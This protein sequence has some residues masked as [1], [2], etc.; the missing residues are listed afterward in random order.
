[1]RLRIAT[2]LALVL[3]AGSALAQD[4]RD[5]TRDKLRKALT[6]GGQRSDVGIDFRQ[7][8]K[9]PYNFVGSMESDLLNTDSL[10]VVV[11]VTESDTISFRIYPHYKGG[12]V[13]LGKA[14]DA[15][16]LMKKL[17]QFNDSNFLFWG[18]DDTDDLFAAYSF[19]LESGF[20]AEAVEIVLRSIRSIDKFTGELRPFIDGSVGAAAK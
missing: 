16:G 11:R 8:S 4:S 17:L 15:R 1:M 9:Q 3:I 18:A 6:A 10:E 20:P 5:V 14:K 7:S 19:T 2:A 13:N 12:Y